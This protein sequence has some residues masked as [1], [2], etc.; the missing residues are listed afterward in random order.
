[1]LRGILTGSEILD[2]ITKEDVEKKIEAL[3]EKD[4]Q[5]WAERSEEFEKTMESSL[6]EDEKERLMLEM[7]NDRISGREAIAKEQRMAA[8]RLRQDYADFKKYQDDAFRAIVAGNFPKYDLEIMKAAEAGNFVDMGLEY[9]ENAHR[10]F[11]NFKVTKM[12][13]ISPEEAEKLKDLT[14]RDQGGQAPR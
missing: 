7:L 10:F 1:M 11:S 2:Y 9:I 14:D 8:L 12:S 6:P 3:L 13:V 4:S 5:R